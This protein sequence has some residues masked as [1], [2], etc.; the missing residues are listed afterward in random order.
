[1]IS[2]MKKQAHEQTQIFLYVL[3]VYF[4]VR[5]HSLAPK[6]AYYVPRE[7]FRFRDININSWYNFPEFIIFINV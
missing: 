2:P 6:S 3:T 1:M 7:V 4:P 5:D